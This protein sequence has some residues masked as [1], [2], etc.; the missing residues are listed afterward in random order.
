MRK[1][2]HW[3]V[4]L[5]VSKKNISME[6]GNNLFTSARNVATG[7]GEAVILPSVRTMQNVWFGDSDR[8][9]SENLMI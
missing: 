9:S 3:I 7:V 4:L 6:V 1:A 2:I 5:A 8:G